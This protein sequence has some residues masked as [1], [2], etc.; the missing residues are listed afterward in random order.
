MDDIEAEEKEKKQSKEEKDAEKESVKATRDELLLGLKRS[1]SNS[2]IIDDE[3]E[4]SPTPD[5]TIRSQK[6]QKNSRVSMI[7]HKFDSDEMSKADWIEV[8]KPQGAS[9]T[10]LDIVE[11]RVEEVSNM[12]ARI[13]STLG[14]LEALIMAGLGSKYCLF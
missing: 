6:R 12:T 1:R 2:N 4:A 13:K 3:N 11:K 8:L 9:N 7:I 10:R 5:I 14:R